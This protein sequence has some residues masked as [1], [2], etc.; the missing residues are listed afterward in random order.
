MR[1][2]LDCEFREDGR[3][4]A[5]ISIGLV[6]DDG[7]EYYAETEDAEDLAAASP[8]LAENVLPLLRGGDA[9]KTNAEMRADLIEFC[10]EKPEIWGWYAAYDWVALCQI[11]GTMMD[12]PEGWP[13]F[14]L[15]AMQIRPLRS[16]NDWLPPRTLPEHHALYDA[17]WQRQVYDYLTQAECVGTTTA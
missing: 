11:F 3:T 12:L 8:W 9:V 15:D 4:I 13:M 16:R 2:W 1:L 14:I 7:A 5:L 6:R 10:G 17:R